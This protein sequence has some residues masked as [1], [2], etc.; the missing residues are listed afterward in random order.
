[1]TRL[2]M[3]RAWVAAE[4]TRRTPFKWGGFRLLTG[5]LPKWCDHQKVGLCVLT[6]PPQTPPNS[7]MAFA[8]KGAAR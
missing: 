3:N 4:V 7:E 8:E 1:M 6:A 5:V 2:P